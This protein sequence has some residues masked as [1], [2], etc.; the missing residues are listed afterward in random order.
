[1]LIKVFFH[2]TIYDRKKQEE[3]SVAAMPVYNYKKGL[4]AMLGCF[5]IWGFQPLYWYLC[6]DMETFFL[7]ASRIIWAA[8]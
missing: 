2:S 1:M 7:M 6:G 5:L 8:V 4:A 3:G